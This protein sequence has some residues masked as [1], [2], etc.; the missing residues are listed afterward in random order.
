MEDDIE[1]PA[2]SN[3]GLDAAEAGKDTEVFEN[4]YDENGK[5]L[6]HPNNVKFE[7]TDKEKK[8]LAKE[9]P[10]SLCRDLSRLNRIKDATISTKRPSLGGQSWLLQDVGAW[11]LPLQRGRGHTWSARAL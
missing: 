6:V 5:F 4:G 10:G 2:V 7:F 11:E 8:T 1:P 9:A 3:E